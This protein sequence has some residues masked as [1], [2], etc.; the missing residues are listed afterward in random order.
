M[1]KIFT[2][3]GIVMLFIAVSF[4]IANA[5]TDDIKTRFLKNFPRMQMQGIEKVEKTDI[6][7]LYEITFSNNMIVYY[8]PEKEYMIFGEIWNNEGKS[9]TAEKRMEIARKKLSSLKLDDA[10]KIGKG[11]KKVVEFFDP[12]CPHCKTVYNYLKDK[13]DKITLNLFPV[14]LFGPNSE[15]KVKYL[16]CEKDK[17]KA[18]DVIFSK[19][20]NEITLPE[21]CDIDNDTL[22]KRKAMLFTYGITGV[23]FLLIDGQPVNGSNIQ[24]IEKLL[25]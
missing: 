2:F 12:E 17:E 15:K 14:P 13:K 23:P 19:P 10:I 1:K 20:A 16:M 5:N 6:K 8:Y 25:N 22:N 9:I 7:G 4:I 18:L 3:T 11:K 24:Q 21:K